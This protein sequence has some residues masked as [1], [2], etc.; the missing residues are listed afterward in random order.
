MEAREKFSLE[1]CGGKPLA[2]QNLVEIQTRKSVDDR[3]F[4][5]GWTTSILA[6]LFSQICS[7]HGNAS[8]AIY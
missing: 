2:Q 7:L 4:K 6:V 5:V 1:I 8:L 3:N